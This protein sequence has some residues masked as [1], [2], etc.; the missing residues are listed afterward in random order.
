MARNKLDGNTTVNRY[1]NAKIK[2][3]IPDVTA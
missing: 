3:Y 1:L 2:Y